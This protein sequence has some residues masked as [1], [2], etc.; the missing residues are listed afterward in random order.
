MESSSRRCSTRTISKALRRSSAIRSS[1]CRRSPRRAKRPPEASFLRPYHTNRSTS[2][3]A[4]N[5]CE[6]ASTPLP[7]LLASSSTINA[8]PCAVERP[9]GSQH[10]AQHGAGERDDE[11]GQQGREKT[12]HIEPARQARCDLDHDR[13]G[14]PARDEPEQEADAE[15]ADA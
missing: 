12:S 5:A 1:T 3:K 9:L 8:P 14:D 13:G 15:R 10:P 11:R 2:S 6:N 4:L 7:V